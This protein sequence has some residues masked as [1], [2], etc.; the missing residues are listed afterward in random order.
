M[1][2]KIKLNVKHFSVSYCDELP[3]QNSCLHPAQNKTNDQGEATFFRIGDKSMSLL[4]EVRVGKD[5][6]NTS[7]K[8]DH[9]FY[10]IPSLAQR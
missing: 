5:P 10:G 6:D 4:T 7:K 9:D 1:S 2:P 8:P 3:T